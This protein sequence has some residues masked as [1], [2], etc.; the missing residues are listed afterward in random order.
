MRPNE[1]RIDR[2]DGTK[3]FFFKIQLLLGSQLKGKWF[4]GSDVVLSMGQV[5]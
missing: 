4:E 3:D 1:W 2:K 5:K